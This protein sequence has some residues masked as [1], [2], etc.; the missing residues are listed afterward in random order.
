MIR[1]PKRNVGQPKKSVRPP[2]EP[3]EIPQ[4]EIR[5]EKSEPTQAELVPVQPSPPPPPTLPVPCGPAKWAEVL[6]PSKLWSL[7]QDLDYYTYRRHTMSKEER[8]VMEARLPPST[9]MA[10]SVADKL[11]DDFVVSA[12]ERM[13]TQSYYSL[14]QQ[15]MTDNAKIMLA[16]R[17]LIASSVEYSQSKITIYR[18]KVMNSADFFPQSQWETMKDPQTGE[19]IQVAKAEE[20][21]ERSEKFNSRKHQVLI[22][23][24]ISPPITDRDKMPTDVAGQMKL[25]LEGYGISIDDP[26]KI[27]DRLSQQSQTSS[28]EERIVARIAYLIM[29][30]AFRKKPPQT[31]LLDDKI[32]D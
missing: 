12:I 19:T 22:E 26:N 28:I 24:F 4:L 10:E 13:G 1:Y 27:W 16:L 8:E 18:N 21:Y 23:F 14:L 25:V 31:P 32:K 15:A 5:A 9:M 29:N 20:G 2:I 30:S 17:C 3:E 7:H 11:L 6:Y